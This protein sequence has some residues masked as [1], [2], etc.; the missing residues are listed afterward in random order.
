MMSHGLVRRN[1]CFFKTLVGTCESTQ[2]HNLDHHQL[3][4]F[5]NLKSENVKSSTPLQKLKQRDMVTA[6]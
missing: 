4:C 6:W 2:Q 1:Q 5:K 3:H